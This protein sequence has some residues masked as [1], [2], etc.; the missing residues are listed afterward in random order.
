MFKTKVF[1][2]KTMAKKFYGEA[3][4]SMKELSGKSITKAKGLKNKKK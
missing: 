2:A 1:I 4:K 3:M